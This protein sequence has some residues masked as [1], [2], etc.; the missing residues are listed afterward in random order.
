MSPS[1]HGQRVCFRPETGGCTPTK[2]PVPLLSQE[3]SNTIPGLR[4]PSEAGPAL[5][6]IR[7]GHGGQEALRTAP[8]QGDASQATLLESGTE[9]RQPP[10]KFCIFLHDVGSG[11]TELLIFSV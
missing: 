4:M 6:P 3:D 5:I 8:G 7:R 1:P 9:S 10:I 2:I 11:L